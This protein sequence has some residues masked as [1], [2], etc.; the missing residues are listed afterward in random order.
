M[1]RAPT[2]Q[3]SRPMATGLAIAA[4]VPSARAENMIQSPKSMVGRS[5]SWAA[6]AD[7]RTVLGSLSTE[8]E[9]VAAPHL[10]ADPKERRGGL[11]KRR[12]GWKG[13]AFR[14]VLFLVLVGAVLSLAA[15]AYFAYDLPLSPALQSPPSRSFSLLG[16]DGKSF[17]FR[18][19]YKG[20]A[21]PYEAL[22]NDLVNAVLAIE[23]RRFFDHNGIDSW[24]VLRAAWVNLRA[25]AIRQGGSTLTQQYVKLAFLTPE[26][27]LRRKVQEALLALWLES[28]LDKKEI[29]RRYI[30]EVYFGAG[31]YGIDAA[32]RRYFGKKSFDLTL[33]E[34]AMLAGLIQAPS[35]LAPTGDLDAAQARA[36]VVVRAMVDAGFIG[37]ARAEKA[38]AEPAALVQLPRGDDGRGYFADW[39]KAQADELL[40]PVYGDFAVQTTL[41]QGL[42]EIAESVLAEHL[43]QEGD[44]FAVGQAALVA[45]APNGA[46]RAMIG[47]RDYL[48]SQF[49]RATQAQRQPGSLF[50]LFVY[51]SAL[52]AGYHPDSSLVDEP[53]E[54]GNWRPKNYTDRYLGRISLRQAFA[55]SVNTVAVLL[56]EAVGRETVAE[57]ARGL[58]ILSP[59][60]VH[61]SLA[62]GTSNVNLLEMVAAYGAVGFGASRLEPYGIVSLGG[63]HP[64]YRHR[65]PASPQLDHFERLARQHMRELLEAAVDSGTGRAADPGIPIAGKTGTSQDH[66]DAWFVGMTN[67]L[68]VGVW[69]GND[70]NRPMKKVT[71]GS[72]PARIWRDFVIRS[73]EQAATVVAVQPA[74]AIATSSEPAVATE[75][76]ESG[77][78]ALDPMTPD[79]TLAEQSATSPLP[80]VPLRA[81]R[82]ARREAKSK[83]VAKRGNDGVLFGHPE[84]LDVATLRFADRIVRL[85]GVRPV[86]A[87]FVEAM[88]SYIG[89]R[90][91]TCRPFDRRAYTCEVGGYDLSEV[92]VYNGGARLTRDAPSQ[93]RRAQAEAQASRVGI[94]ARQ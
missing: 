71:G 45:L 93:L 40:G 46:V 68:A 54:V 86:G 28:R 89:D 23:D 73:R 19:V 25:G 42:Q 21:V 92:V 34:C 57:T 67:D 52:R 48:A 1:A 6:P 39:V 85:F 77:V 27:T 53:I 69:V 94:W 65:I 3:T 2:G 31:A 81:D 12:R 61:P 18:G 22:P 47:G 91:V 84:V 38:I 41:D 24:G 76:D 75:A 15:A 35:R 82:Q 30:N 33:A 43:E 50:K 37:E 8:L 60:Q 51:L 78:D 7:N 62:L 14:L 11:V 17:A 80:P 29:F 56:T 59:L 63:D 72:L 70:D 32:A 66:R 10:R 13:L 83:Q 20:S 87:D 74:D 79:A 58:G 49:N 90:V 44:E 88:R 26:R 36:E 16:E 5:A 64:L 4:P 55:K 9:S